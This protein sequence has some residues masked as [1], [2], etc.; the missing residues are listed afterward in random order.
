[1]NHHHHH[2]SQQ[3]KHEAPSTCTPVAQVSS[4]SPSPPLSN[5]SFDLDYGELLRQ[6][7]GFADYSKPK[8]S[9]TRGNDTVETKRV[10]WHRDLVLDALEHR[11]LIFEQTDDEAPSLGVHSKQAA[12]HQL[13]D[14][15]RKR[16]LLFQLEIQIENSLRSIGHIHRE[17]AKQLK[18][19]FITVQNDHGT[20]VS[21]QNAW[22]RH[23]AK[24]QKL[25]DEIS[26]EERVLEPLQIQLTDAHAG[27]K[28]AE[29][30]LYIS[31]AGG[32]RPEDSDAS[33]E[34]RILEAMYAGLGAAP[35]NDA[36]FHV[37]REDDV[38][39]L[40]ERSIPSG[41]VQDIASVSEADAQPKP[42]HITF[43]SDIMTPS[44]PAH[45]NGLSNKASVKSERSRSRDRCALSAEKRQ[46]AIDAAT[47]CCGDLFSEQ[48]LCLNEYMNEAGRAMAI[49]VQS[50]AEVRRIDLKYAL[51][52]DL[53]KFDASMTM[54][55]NLQ[56][57]AALGVAQRMTNIDVP[58][59]HRSQIILF[60]GTNMSQNTALE[61]SRTLLHG[62]NSLEKIIK[63]GSIGSIGSIAQLY[64]ILQFVRSLEV[65]FER[66]PGRDH[67]DITIGHP[68]HDGASSVGAELGS[69]ALTYLAQTNKLSAS[70][71]NTSLLRALQE[72]SLR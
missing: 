27:V 33:S 20:A 53:D 67:P 14:I 24:F 62:R 21:V 50:L 34:D 13:K 4:S 41:I 3:A 18:N 47:K 64:K 32:S 57:P 7:P 60:W 22:Q 42:Q 37:P 56:N 70:F 35:D 54:I 45:A 17:L 43:G 36:S 23:L 25:F 9:S 8:S 51:G 19:G 65:T 59:I 44:K 31:L 11:L 63:P 26:E 12:L 28:K 2:R 66:Y 55:Q 49:G 58:V 68:A 48:L 38:L 6:I 29:E 52:F 16:A 71:S 1:M 61:F 72:H 46:T 39:D 30:D 69:D 5:A 15:I 10:H 40:P